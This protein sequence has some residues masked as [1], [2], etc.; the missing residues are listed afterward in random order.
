MRDAQKGWV[1]IAGLGPG[2]ERMVIPEVQ[3]VLAE[4]THVVGY[5]PCVERIAPHAGLTLH[6]SDNRV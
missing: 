6:A 5:I 1:V 3:E 2:D 4:A